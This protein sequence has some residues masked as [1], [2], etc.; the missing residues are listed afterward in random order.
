MKRGRDTSLWDSVAGGRVLE[1]RTLLG[2]RADVDTVGDNGLT[3]FMCASQRGNIKMMELLLSSRANVDAVNARGENALACAVNPGLSSQEPDVG[4]VMFLLEA[5]A[6]VD[7]MDLR[8]HRPW[9]RSLCVGAC[10]G[11]GRSGEASAVSV[12]ALV[13][14]GGSTSLSRLY[15][16]V[17][18]GDFGGVVDVLEGSCAFNVD[19]VDRAQGVDW[20]PLVKAAEDGSV[21]I[22]TALLNYRANVAVRTRRGRT[23]LS[24]AACPSGGA[25]PD[26]DRDGVIEVLL[27]Y[28]ADSCAENLRVQAAC[29]RVFG[30]GQQCR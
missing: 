3:L 8:V 22:V 20:P 1:V 26:G 5:R 7:K 10:G 23:A 4:A 18:D 19:A 17:K 9:M 30:R 15:G 6:D 12:A 14:A 24:F 28:G 2:M 29:M 27:M 16:A 13:A 11:D 21:D 25:R